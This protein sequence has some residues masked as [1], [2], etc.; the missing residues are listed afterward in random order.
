MA[1]EGIKAFKPEISVIIGRDYGGLSFDEVIKA[2]CDFS[3]LE[4][5]TYI[6]LLDRIK[7][8]AWLLA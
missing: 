7:S 1:N 8:M 2:K 5:I 6:E 4:V 3:S